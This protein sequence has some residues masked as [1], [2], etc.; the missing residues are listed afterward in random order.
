MMRRNKNRFKS[1]DVHH[2]C[3]GNGKGDAISGKV[4]VALI[5]N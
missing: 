5:A 3:S 4:N 1:P 2:S